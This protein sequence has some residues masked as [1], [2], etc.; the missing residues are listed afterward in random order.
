MDIDKI[1]SELKKNRVWSSRGKDWPELAPCVFCGGRA[2][3]VVHDPMYGKCGAWVKCSYCGA[4]GPTASIYALIF[5]GKTMCTPL[6][7]ESL[8]R[9]INAAVDSWDSKTVDKRR[10]GNMRI[11]A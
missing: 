10:L 7:P 3:V 11:T 9:G 1:M 2:I 8:E 6:L 5:R 4:E